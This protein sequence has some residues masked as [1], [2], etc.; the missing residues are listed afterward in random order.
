ML[1]KYCCTGLTFT[2][3]PRE[4]HLIRP[5]YIVI[6]FL[7]RC[8]FARRRF[9]W[10]SCISSQIIKKTLPESDQSYWCIAYEVSECE[11]FRMRRQNSWRCQRGPKDDRQWQDNRGSRGRLVQRRKCKRQAKVR[12]NQLFPARHY[13]SASGKFVCILCACINKCDLSHCTISVSYFHKVKVIVTVQ[14]QKKEAFDLTAGGS[15]VL[16]FCACNFIL[17]A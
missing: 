14:V 1:T 8:F 15:S 16:I 10:T 2:F 7:V 12:E 13:N 5:A 11:Q 4:F 9:R 3:R 17:W 6:T